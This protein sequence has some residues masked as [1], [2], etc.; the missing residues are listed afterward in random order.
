MTKE[1]TELLDAARAGDQRAFAALTS[2]HRRE[3]ELHCYRLLGSQHDAQDALQETLVAAWEGLRSFEA[4][5]SVRTWL[6]RIATNQCLDARRRARRR[7]AKAWDI[8]GVALLPPSGTDE[9]VWLEPL[10]DNLLPDRSNL[11]ASPHAR[12]DELESVSLAFISALQRLPPRQLAVVVLRDVLGFSAQEVAEILVTTVESVTSALKRGR[13]N[14]ARH[15]SPLDRQ[16]TASLSPLQ[17][18]V[19]ERFAHAWEAA[20]PNAI[21]A[22]LTSDAVMNM[23]PMTYRYDGP[24]LIARFCAGL[25]DA[26]RRFRL[27]PT[28]ANGQ[29]AFGAYLATE[30]VQPAVGLYVLT[31]RGDRIAGLTRFELS[32][33]SEFGLPENLAS[34]RVESFTEL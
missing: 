20:D 5:S 4:R 34:T 13:A 17:Q 29:P 33:P 31:L 9:V 30:R 24:A 6:Y 11:S 18:D 22:L 27:V 8:P 25:F 28:R 26:G 7:P 14:L 12:Y 3:L 32:T 16:S 10:P 21:V 23:P 15:L 19:V 2:P 1:T